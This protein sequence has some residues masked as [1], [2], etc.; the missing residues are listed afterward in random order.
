MRP[1]SSIERS[2]KGRHLKVTH[3]TPN[4]LDANI[5][6]AIARRAFE[7]S[8]S[9]GFVPGH[10]MEDWRRAESEV[11]RPLNCGFLVSD[12]QIELTTDPACF[13]E[14]E[15]KV[16]VEPRRL[17]ICGTERACQPGKMPER[18]ASHT[19]KDVIF[20]SLKLPHEVLPSQASARFKGGVLQ[21]DLPTAQPMQAVRALKNAA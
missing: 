8:E 7:I 12:N 3:F 21:I 9:R 17:V 4:G 19:G 11:V 1:P 20:R 13:D 2:W 15:I 18:N 16:C 6:D 14:G 10:E 5:R